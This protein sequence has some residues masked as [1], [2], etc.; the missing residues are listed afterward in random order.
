T[1]T[2]GCRRTDVPCNYQAR[3]FLGESESLRSSESRCRITGDGDEYD[4]RRRG[5]TGGAREDFRGW[6]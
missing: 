1:I 4:R 5:I 2:A 6:R 3:N